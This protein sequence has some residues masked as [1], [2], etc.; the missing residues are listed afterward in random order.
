MDTAQVVG[1]VINRERY[2][3]SGEAVRA[4]AELGGWA[5]AAP[6]GW[7]CRGGCSLSAADRLSAGAGFCYCGEL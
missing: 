5:I 7:A 4:V 2:Q 1:P 6:G 3:S